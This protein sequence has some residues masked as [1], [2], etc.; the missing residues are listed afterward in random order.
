MARPPMTLGRGLLLAALLGPASAAGIEF[1]TLFTSAEERA[2]IDRLRRGEPAVAA[3]LSEHPATPPQ[4]TGYVKRSDGQN[5]LWIDG[6]AVPTRNPKSNE[7][8]DPR[9][10]RDDAVRLPEKSIRST[11]PAPPAAN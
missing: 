4:L 10:V 1:G 2:R 3:A 6:V 8:L 11:S 5:T 7:L 9:K